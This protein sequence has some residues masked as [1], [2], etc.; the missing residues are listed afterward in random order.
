MQRI[1]RGRVRRP[2]ARAD[3]PRGSNGCLRAF[4]KHPASAALIAILAACHHGEE[5]PHSA[6]RYM[7]A[8]ARTS[9][10]CDPASA[11]RAAVTQN[12]H[13]LAS[14]DR[15]RIYVE[16]PD[17]VRTARGVALLGGPTWV[18][19]SPT[20]FLDPN[21]PEATLG[22]RGLPLY[23]GVV[24]DTSGAVTTAALPAGPSRMRNARS[25]PD[26][27]G[28][29]HV[30]WGTPP[31]SAPE[32]STTSTLWY[33]HFD[34]EAWGQ[35]ERV[36]SAPSV[37]NWRSSVSVAVVDGTLYVAAIVNDP[38]R[39]WYGREGVLIAARAGEGE[40]SHSWIDLRG[41]QAFV[42]HIAL[43]GLASDELLLAI[44]GVV[45][46]SDGATRGT[47]PDGAPQN[48]IVVLRSADSGSTW[49]VP[50]RVTT[51]PP[52][53]GDFLTAGVGAAGQVY[54]AWLSGPPKETGG[55]D[56][57]LDRVQAVVTR[58]GREWRHSAV[59]S[60]GTRIYSFAAAA[61]AQGT[62]Y[63]AAQTPERGAIAMAGWSGDGRRGGTHGGSWTPVFSVPTQGP[64]SPLTLSAVSGDSLYLT[65]GVAHF[66]RELPA[67][68]APSLGFLRWAECVG[69]TQ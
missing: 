10:A 12:V 37:T 26:G 24:L 1:S 25:V 51:L 60:L 49:S 4:T 27:R 59:L 66:L 47:A 20:A 6:S 41:R 28:G 19:S 46:D 32:A 35:P 54:L 16:Q 34:G 56:Y 30:V 17:A 31:D 2:S 22:P 61:T 43:A 50:D 40:W 8:P 42:R 64:S 3:I 58:D 69:G 23:A 18:W 21:N 11:L 33:A 39:A 63:I 5:R 52:G 48:G 44:A 65:W 9:D 53:M 45:I 68:A 62:L 14:A 38:S 67:A 36:V 15:R 29:A 13:E 55:A 7:L 57:E